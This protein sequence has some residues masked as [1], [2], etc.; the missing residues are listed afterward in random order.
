ML[1]FIQSCWGQ[2]GGTSH[3]KTSIMHLPRSQKSWWHG[4]GRHYVPEKEEALAMPT[5]HLGPGNETETMVVKISG[6][7]SI[8]RH[9]RPNM[10]GTQ[11][12]TLI[13][14]TTHIA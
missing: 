7:L 6:V 13:L 1:S 12:G 8:V 11:K 5:L 14:T 4:S 9:L 2:V 3:L 10:Y